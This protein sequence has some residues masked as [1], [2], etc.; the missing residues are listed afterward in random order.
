MNQSAK[1]KQKAEEWGK[2]LNGPILATCVIDCGEL[3]DTGAPYDRE[4]RQVD[5]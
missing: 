1:G 2:K 3:V 5:P 4:I